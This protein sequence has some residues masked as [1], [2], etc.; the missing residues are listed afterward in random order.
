MQRRTSVIVTMSNWR[1]GA[2]QGF[3]PHSQVEQRALYSLEILARVKSDKEPSLCA[4]RIIV[5]IIVQQTT[6]ACC[7]NKTL[8]LQLL[9]GGR[10]VEN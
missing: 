6:R 3:P 10:R 9:A 1:A 7:V 5:S 8:C 2:S 4:A